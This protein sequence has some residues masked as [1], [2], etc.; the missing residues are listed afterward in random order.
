MLQSL[1]LTTHTISALFHHCSLSHQTISIKTMLLAFSLAFLPLLAA[2]QKYAVFENTY[3]SG[4][5]GAYR[6]VQLYESGC[7]TYCDNC[8]LIFVVSTAPYLHCLISRFRCEL[9]W[10]DLGRRLN[11]RLNVLFAHIN[12]ERHTVRR[13]PRLRRPYSI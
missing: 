10:L 5:G 12:N 9:H 13:L 3:R 8:Q 1:T 7:E 11:A 4:A 6:P 2:A